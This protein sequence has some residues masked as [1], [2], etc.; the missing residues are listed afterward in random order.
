MTAK[1]SPTTQVYRVYIKATSQAVWDAITK[2]EF[3]ERFG[4]GGRVEYDLRPG[5]GYRLAATEE[6]KQGGRAMGFEVPDVMVDG[7]VIE[8]NP[9]HTLV[10]TFRMLMDPTVAEEG[11]TRV[12]YQIDEVQGGVSRLTVTHELE[13]AAGLA[14]LVSGQNED[15][16]AGGGW[17]FVLSSLKTLIETGQPLL[18][19]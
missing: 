8:A 7:E 19:G 18:H 1:P 5:G 11:F 15:Q 17:N 9:P 12:T 13:G 2:P 16:G 10:Q 14:S 6:I 4:Y 3:T